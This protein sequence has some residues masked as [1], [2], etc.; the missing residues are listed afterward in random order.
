MMYVCPTTYVNL[1]W[2]CFTHPI[3][4]AQKIVSFGLTLNMN[5]I[6]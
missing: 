5:F 6:E 3:S 1:F 2:E 4:L